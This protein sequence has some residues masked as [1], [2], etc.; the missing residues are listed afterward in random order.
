MVL[1]QRCWNKKHS[2]R[3]EDNS[4]D[5]WLAGGSTRA[6]MVMDELSSSASSKKTKKGAEVPLG[7]TDLNFPPTVCF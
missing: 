2:L 4:G 7:D 3:G 1:F 5:V 6:L